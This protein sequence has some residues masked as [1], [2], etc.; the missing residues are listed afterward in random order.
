MSS[1]YLAAIVLLAL[2]GSAIALWLYGGAAKVEPTANIAAKASSEA[3]PARAVA[4]EQDVVASSDAAP[5]GESD[6]DRDARLLGWTPRLER[7]DSGEGYQCIEVSGDLVC[8][9]TRNRDWV[10]EL[11]DV[12]LQQLGLTD[13][14]AAFLASD[15]LYETDPDRSYEFALRAVALSGK[16]EPLFG[17]QPAHDPTLSTQENEFRQLAT[18]GV[19]RAVQALHRERD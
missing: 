12:A 16:T 17:V 19:S 15:R 13:A 10:E 8:G 18:I 9:N 2:T 1:K 6:A 3:R 4:D 14:Y 11:D 5:H 7:P